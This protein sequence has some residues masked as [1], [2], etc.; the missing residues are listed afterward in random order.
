MKD[1]AAELK[2]TWENGLN[3]GESMAGGNTTA[4]DGDN[5]AMKGVGSES[6]YPRPEVTDAPDL[7]VSGS[8]NTMPTT[9]MGV[10]KK[11]DGSW[12]TSPM[13]TGFQKAG[14]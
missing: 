8:A 12:T 11:T 14:E 13:Q 9:L 1:L 2:L 4:H 3:A 7:E 6:V 5:H 10:G